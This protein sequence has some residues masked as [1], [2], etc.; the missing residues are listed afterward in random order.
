VRE[1]AARLPDEV[2]EVDTLNDE[3]ALSD[4]TDETVDMSLA[5]LKA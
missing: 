5:E 1:A 2:E 4:A 3:D